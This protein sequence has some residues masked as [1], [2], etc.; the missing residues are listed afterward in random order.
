MFT[1]SSKKW[2]PCLCS[3][4]SQ[5]QLNFCRW[6][7]Y[8]INSRKELEM[9]NIWMEINSCII[10]RIYS[11]CFFKLFDDCKARNCYG[12]LPSF[13]YPVYSGRPSSQFHNWLYPLN[14]YAHLSAN[15]DWNIWKYLYQIFF[16][17]YR[18]PCW[19]MH[20]IIWNSSERIGYR[21]DR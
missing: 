2:H 5:I 13:F 20:S 14:K 19:E 17:K 16:S 9:A 7:F 6:H 11:F 3:I 12:N 8:R 21:Y 4:K 10:V 18:S 15:M 1:P